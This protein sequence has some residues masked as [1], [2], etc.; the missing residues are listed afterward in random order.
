[1]A[2]DV[3]LFVAA[4]AV[5]L[6]SGQTPIGDAL[7]VVGSLLLLWAARVGLSRRSA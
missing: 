5:R 1:V 7:Y 4:G 3:L 6:Q 2:L